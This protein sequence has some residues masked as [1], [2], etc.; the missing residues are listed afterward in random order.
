M[1]GAGLERPGQGALAR[2]DRA[3]PLAQGSPV[4]RVG[5]QGL[6]HL[7]GPLV[8]GHA[9]LDGGHR[10]GLEQVGEHGLG[11]FPLGR[12][13]GL[14]VQVADELGQQRPG[15]DRRGIGPAD[16]AQIRPDVQRLHGGR[17]RR[18]VSRAAA[19]PGIHSARVGG[20]TQVDG[21]GDA[22]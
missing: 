21:V 13:E 17:G 1:P 19:R 9:H 2:A 20:S 3:A 22:R 18:R 15:R 6:R 8:G 10:H 5:G 14:A 4:G 7:A 11:P 12:A 16:R